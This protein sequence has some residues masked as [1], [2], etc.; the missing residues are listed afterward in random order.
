MDAMIKDGPMFDIID[1]QDLTEEKKC[2]AIREFLLQNPM[3]LSDVKLGLTPLHYAVIK[4]LPKVVKTLIELGSPI[5]A[6]D[7]N[8]STP[9]H[10]AAENGLSDLIVLLGYHQCDFNALDTAQETALHKAIKNNH[11][12]CVKSL[13]QVSQFQ[14]DTSLRNDKGNTAEDCVRQITHIKTQADLARA[15]STPADLFSRTSLHLAIINNLPQQVQ[16]HLHL[17]APINAKD[18]TGNTALHYAV[19]C[20]H[21]ALLLQ[22]CY[23]DK[24]DLNCVDNEGNTALHKCVETGYAE[25]IKILVTSK[26][27]MDKT[28]KNK[29]NL[30]AIE[31]VASHKEDEANILNKALAST[32]VSNAQSEEME[33]N[34]FN[35]ETPCPSNLIPFLKENF[36][37]LDMSIKTLLDNMDSPRRYTDGSINKLLKRKSSSPR[38]KSNNLVNE[39]PV[40]EKVSFFDSVE[41]A[42]LKNDVACIIS[43][44]QLDQSHDEY[45]FFIEEFN[46]L[47]KKYPISPVGLF[48]NDVLGEVQLLLLQLHSAFEKQNSAFQLRLQ[49]KLLADGMQ[50]MTFI[51]EVNT[52]I[53]NGFGEVRQIL[54]KLCSGTLIN[55]NKVLFDL[56]TLLTNVLGLMDVVEP[57][58]LIANLTQL[59]PLFSKEQRLQ[60]HYVVL[61]L[62]DLLYYYGFDILDLDRPLGKEID[63]YLQTCCDEAIQN[64]VTGYK[65]E[66][67]FFKRNPLHVFAEQ[68][69][70]LVLPYTNTPKEFILDKIYEFVNHSSANIKYNK[71]LL[72]CVE[73]IAR[74]FNI[75]NARFYLN[76]SLNDMRKAYWK[77]DKQH[78]SLMNYPID[79]MCDFIV[80]TVV[81][82]NT[83]QKQA[84]AMTL[85]ILVARESLHYSHGVDMVAVMAIYSAFSKL[86]LRSELKQAFK[87]LDT[88]TLLIKDSLDKLLSP[89]DNLKPYRDLLVSEPLVLPLIEVIQRDKMHSYEHLDLDS[90]AF[91]LGKIHNSLLLI[92]KSLIGLPLVS[93]SDLSDKLHL[94]YVIPD[95]SQSSLSSKEEQSTESSPRKSLSSRKTSHNKERKGLTLRKSSVEKE[96]SRKELSL[97][98]H[99]SLFSFSS[100]APILSPKEKENKTEKN[101]AALQI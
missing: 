88:T 64:I 29:A 69:R 80:H 75:I 51:Q 57:H 23:H 42:Y 13:L 93:Q 33:K 31:L 68:L 48:L 77:N 19:L 28:I 63:N 84:Q 85:F 10:L 55:S 21:P 50:K 61:R 14:I 72:S 47:I 16:H 56:K 6:T 99:K 35:C 66:L 52:G 67:A 70:D 24:I 11:P 26:N 78:A 25:G 38:N 74:E 34:I 43:R 89:F 100:S 62:I 86:S 20:N 15:L 97:S 65:N 91:I 73:Y 101:P 9:L 49:K 96:S 39:L 46:R 5:N 76:L 81:S 95:E 54:A 60:S 27:P 8:Q 83:P 4:N 82:L 7:Y 1:R 40:K 32:H 18:S 3:A 45:A 94:K 71:K 12:A 37:E 36:K 59:N 58:E 2:V 17:G 92:K 44:I 30:T 41:A 53:D 87:L 22:L 79:T 98:H 90:D